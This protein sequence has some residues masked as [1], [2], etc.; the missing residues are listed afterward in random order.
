MPLMI[1][2]F[3][4]DAGP[5]SVVSVEMI[6]FAFHPAVIRLSAGRPATLVLE[7]RGQL[8]H[9]FETSYLRTVPTVV[10]T[11]ALRVEA[12]GITVVRLQPGATA[13][14]TFVPTMRGRFSFACTIEGHREAGMAGDLEIR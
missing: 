12:S 14:V 8:A 5:A 1:V 2:P 7:N 9:Q 11:D 3:H 10:V 4:V 13:K 6:E